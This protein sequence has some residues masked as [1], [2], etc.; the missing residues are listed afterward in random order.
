MRSNKRRGSKTKGRVRMDKPAPSMRK[1]L[2]GD[3][4]LSGSW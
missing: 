4:Y 1:N 2:A 3:A